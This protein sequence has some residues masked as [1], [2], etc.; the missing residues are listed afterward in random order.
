MPNE[1][2]L[3]F[4]SEQHPATGIAFGI[5]NKEVSIP[6]GHCVGTVDCLPDMEILTNEMD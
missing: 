4:S 1:S 5:P 2:Q 6:G 3:L